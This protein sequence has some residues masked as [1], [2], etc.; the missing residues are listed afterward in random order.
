[1]TGEPDAVGWLGAASAEDMGT[2]IGREVKEDAEDDGIH[3]HWLKKLRRL[4][5]YTRDPVAAM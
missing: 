4:Q 5:S 3:R 1:M 2:S